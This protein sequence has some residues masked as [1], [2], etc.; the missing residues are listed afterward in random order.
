MH[1]DEYPE[2]T[3]EDK[4]GARGMTIVQDIVEDKFEWVFRSQTTRDLGIDA[5]IEVVDGS[6]ATGK[7]IAVQ[8]K[9]GES[10]LNKTTDIGYVFRPKNKHINYWLNHSLPVI[11][12][13]CHPNTRECWWVEVAAET[14]HSTGKSWKIILPFGQRFDETYKHV[15][16]QIA[17]RTI[18]DR[19]RQRHKNRLELAPIIDD[20]EIVEIIHRG[21]VLMGFRHITGPDYRVLVFSQ[22]Y[23]LYQSDSFYPLETWKNILALSGVEDWE[24]EE[25][26]EKA[27]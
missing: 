27:E 2:V 9:C 15:L 17:G 10:F 26:L 19:I 23:M 21:G 20:R 5:H 12:V 4:L 3:N 24:I 8:I 6:K 7:V 25:A 14:V 16:F 1:S 13:I 11:M 22:D 18:A